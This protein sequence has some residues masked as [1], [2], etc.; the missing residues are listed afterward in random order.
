MSRVS[1]LWRWYI[2]GGVLLLG[3]SFSRG[4][5]RPRRSCWFDVVITD[6]AIL[7]KHLHTLERRRGSRSADDMFDTEYIVTVN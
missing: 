6:G 4:W 1:T 3:H 7:S 2:R 5:G